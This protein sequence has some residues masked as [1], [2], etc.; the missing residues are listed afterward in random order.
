[1]GKLTSE[2]FKVLNHCP[3]LS[4]LQGVAGSGKSLTIAAKATVAANENKRVLVMRFN[5]SFLKC[6]SAFVDSFYEPYKSQ[7]I[8]C[9]TFIRFLNEIGM[10]FY[11][12][13]EH[14]SEND[15]SFY[16]NE[17]IGEI[18]A[19]IS[20][21]KKKIKWYKYFDLILIDDAQDFSKSWIFFIKENFLNEDGELLIAADTRQNIYGRGKW[22]DSPCFRKKEIVNREVILTTTF[23]MPQNIWDFSRYFATDYL[24]NEIKKENAFQE[25]NGDL[26]WID[27]LDK[28][29]ECDFSDIYEE[30][31]KLIRSGAIE[32]EITILTQ[33]HK[34][35]R[36]LV[37][38]FASK[39]IYST[40]IFG[41]DENSK[42]YRFDGKIKFDTDTSYLK[43]CTTNSFNG[44]QN[45]HILLLIENVD[46]D[47]KERDLALLYLGITRATKSLV[48]FNN[49]EKFSYIYYEYNLLKDLRLN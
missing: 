4:L 8:E 22:I 19:E 37:S 27:K 1:M 30:Y 24:K 28:G 29:R 36:F 48:I 5:L 34:W 10:I 46:Y 7:N 49:V 47:Y 32:S 14:E 31:K 45:G 12:K 21:Q 43:I 35:G 33:T 16:I 26:K 38:Q 15:T 3:G 41:E 25:K 44:F 42:N 2:Q 18:K 9:M 39:G 13:Q 17:M 20:L 23:R 11:F 40:H 6:Y